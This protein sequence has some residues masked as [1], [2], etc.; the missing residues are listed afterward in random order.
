MARSKKNE[1]TKKS[2]PNMSSPAAPIP[3]PSS[4][5]VLHNDDEELAPKFSWILFVCCLPQQPKK[6]LRRPRIDV[7]KASA[8]AMSPRIDVAQMPEHTL[9]EPSKLLAIIPEER[10]PLTSPSRVSLSSSNE[11]TR[12][13]AHRG[14]Y[15]TVETMRPASPK[16]YP[17]GHGQTKSTS[18]LHR[19]YSQ[20]SR[21][22]LSFEKGSSRNS[23]ASME[24]IDIHFDPELLIPDL[25]PVSE[26]TIPSSGS[27]EST[28]SHSSDSTAEPTNRPSTPAS[29]IASLRHVLRSVPSVENILR[30]KPS[31][32]SVFTTF[33]RPPIKRHSSSESIYRTESAYDESIYSRPAS[34]CTSAYSTMLS[35]SPSIYRKAVKAL[36]QTPQYFLDI[37]D[38]EMRPP[39][40]LKVRSTPNSPE[41]SSLAA[42][43]APYKQSNL[44][45]QISI[46]DRP[47]LEMDWEDLDSI[48]DNFETGSIISTERTDGS[49]GHRSVTADYLSTLEKDHSSITPTL[50]ARSSNASTLRLDKDLPLPP[51]SMP[52]TVAVEDLTQIPELEY[53]PSSPI[54]PLSD[55]V[56]RTPLSRH[57]LSSL[58]SS[59]PSDFSKSHISK[60]AISAAD[61]PPIPTR[62][63]P[64]L[65]TPS[66][67]GRMKHLTGLR[68]NHNAH[69]PTRMAGGGGFAAAEHEYQRAMSGAAL[70][71]RYAVA[72]GDPLRVSREGTSF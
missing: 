58:F 14:S 33:P 12:V 34:V 38:D 44:R 66:L 27:L 50:S 39:V 8:H 60:C 46:D 4:A 31:G 10:Q 36:P 45:V 9:F 1:V 7:H 22:R 26:H 42:R 41:M 65:S 67:A 19:R 48:L 61:A 56:P 62:R 72:K 54:S 57:R 49:E 16:M 28:I 68:A 32:E 17:V 6:R 53:D 43:M 11:S 70:V 24:E 35:R 20:T 52:L 15:G 18:S 63:R 69:D 29:S 25:S 40:P 55:D 3:L 21:K 64:M 2:S 13:A 71:G 30:S 47:D 5:T 51:R 23:Q 59:G 37:L